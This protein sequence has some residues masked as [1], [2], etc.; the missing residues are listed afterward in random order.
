MIICELRDVKGAITIYLSLI[1]N[2]TDSFLYC[3]F[4]YTIEEIARET[5][6]QILLVYAS[7]CYLD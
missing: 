4:Y 7:V 5:L 1:L 2:I 3:R 6:F